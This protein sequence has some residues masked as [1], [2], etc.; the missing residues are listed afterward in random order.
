[1]GYRK[2]IIAV[3][4]AN[5]TEVEK[6]QTVAKMISENFKFRA[7]DIIALAPMIQKNGAV[8]SAAIRA[9]SQEGMAGVVK[10]VPYLVK[11]FKR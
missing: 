11:N 7:S 4:C 2:I 3:D 1:M 5:D 9:I 8:I 10:T 6:V